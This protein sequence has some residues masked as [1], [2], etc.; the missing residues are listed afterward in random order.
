MVTDQTNGNQPFVRF[1]D[2]VSEADLACAPEIEGLT[3]MQS[4]FVWAFILTGGKAERSAELAGYG[5]GAKNMAFRN[6]AKRKIQEAIADKLKLQPGS[7]L[8]TA[9]GALYR[10]LETGKDERAVVAAATALMD[11][12]GMA[13]PKG[14]AVA[15]QI[16][17]NVGSAEAQSIL[18]DVQ[19][20]RQARLTQ[21]SDI[22]PAMS[23]TTAAAALDA[24]DALAAAA[25]AGLGGQGGER[26]ERVPSRVPVITP[27]SPANSASTTEGLFD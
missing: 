10:V 20:A 27:P 15:V 7:A 25:G 26:L 9:I 2:S 11:R 4:R 5:G 19:A 13:A 24:I 8:A 23:D 14:P 3:A 22:P 12:F 21:K 1:A 18:A 16:N 17:N 6:L